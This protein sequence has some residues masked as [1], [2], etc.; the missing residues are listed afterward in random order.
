MDAVDRDN[1]ALELVV[2]PH[3]RVGEQ[4]HHDRRRVGHP[5]RLDDDATER[6]YLVRVPPVE[7]V[8]QLVGE[9]APQDAAD[10]AAREQHRSLVH[11]P[12]EV[13]VDAD[14]T[15]LVHDHG[16]LSDPGVIEQAGDERR[17]AA[18]EKAGDEDDGSL[19]RLSSARSA[20]SSGSSGAAEQP[21][22]LAPHGADVLDD[23]RGALA[24]SQDVDL[25][26]PVVQREPEVAEHPVQQ[27]R[28]EHPGPPASILLGPVLIQDDT[29]ECTH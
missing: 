23:G 20:G 7:E 16:R 22:R 14:L 21:L 12:Q 25:S 19:H 4:S 5:G 18:A 27:R 2:I 6:R 29:A 26:G 8:T 11:P 13:V 10:A 24:V 28:A 3:D 15:E 9:V 17:L 1:H